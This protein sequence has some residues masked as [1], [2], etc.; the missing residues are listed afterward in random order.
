MPRTRRVNP[1]P[2][3]EVE[4]ETAPVTRRRRRRDEDDVEATPRRRHRRDEE[5]AEETGDEE[6]DEE[7]AVIPISRGRKAIKKQS[8]NEGGGASAFFRWDEEAQLVKFLESEPWSYQQHWVTREGKQSFP[9]L[10]KGCPLCDI[11]IKQTT[12]VV[13]TILNLTPAKG[14]D[15]LTQTLEVGVTLEETL[16]TFDRDKKVGP[17]DRLYWSLSRSEGARS[18]GSMR[19]YNYAIAPVKDRDLEEDWELDLDDVE[20]AVDEAEIPEPEEVLGKW[21]RSMLQEIADE[22]MGH[23]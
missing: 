9:C 15:F 3:E 8:A 21:T 13:Y 12:K 10:G 6:S 5:P 11:G 23:G 17:L 2:V 1:E 16:A 7:S 19:K 14:D 20:A 4:E 22:A 18:S